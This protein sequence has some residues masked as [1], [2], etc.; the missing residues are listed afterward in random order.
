MSARCALPLFFPL[1]LLFYDPLFA[2]IDKCGTVQ[3]N[4]RLKLLNDATESEFTFEQWLSTRIKAR[5]AARTN[6]NLQPYKIPVVVHI[7]HRGE[8]VGTGVNISNAQVLS[9]IKVLNADFRRL[10][11]DSINTPQVFRSVA[12]KMNIEFILAQQSPDGDASNGIVRVQ[13]SRNQ[14]S[15]DD[16][17]SLKALSYWPAEDYLNIWVTDLSSTLLGYAQFPESSLAGLEGASTNRL[18]DGVVVDYQVFGSRAD[19]NFNLLSSFPNGRTTVHEVG[20]FFGLRHIWGDVTNC[21]TTTDYVDDTPRQDGSTSGCPSHPQSSCSNAKMFQNYMDYTNDACMNLFTKNQVDRMVTVIESSPRRLSLL[22]SKGV[23]HPGPV[24]NDAGLVAITSPAESNCDL[25]IVPSVQVRN[26]GTNAITSVRVEVSVNDVAVETRAF[27]FSP[28]LATNTSAT[29]TFSNRVLNPGLF[30]IRF[31]VLNTNGVEDGKSSDNIISISTRIPETI[32]SPFSQAFNQLP[33]AWPITNDDNGTT[34][35]LTTAANESTS[36]TALGLNLFSSSAV[37]GTTDVIVSPV[38]SLANANSPYFSFDVAYAQRGSNADALRV[39]VISNCGG[40]LETNKVFDKSGSI[41]S[42]AGSLSSSFVPSGANQWRKEVIDLSAYK[43][44]QRVQLAFVG[45]N[46]RG[47]NIYLDN[48][49]V[50]SNLLEDVALRTVLQPSPVR[51]GAEVNPVIVVE[52]TGQIAI[53]NLTVAYH[54]NNGAVLTSN[55]GSNFSLGVKQRIQIT[56]PQVTLQQGENVLNIEL[57]RPNGWHDLNPA[58]NSLSVKS[59]VNTAQDRIPLREN[60]TTASSWTSVSPLSETTWSTA[61]TNFG[62]SYF[63]PS[64][65]NAAVGEEA[66]FVTPTLDFSTSTTA[67]VFYNWS[68]RLRDAGNSQRGSSL[69]TLKILGS[70]DCGNTYPITLYAASGAQLATAVDNTAWTPQNSNEWILQY[71]NLNEL[72]GEENVRLAFVFRNGNGNNYYI[73]NAEFF[74]SDNPAP[75]LI[76]EPFFVFNNAS[77]EDLFVTFKLEERQQVWYEL[78]DVS[79]RSLVREE[80]QDVLNQTFPVATAYASPGLYILRIRIGHQYFA[81]KVFLD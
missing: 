49:A 43:G 58:D 57:T 78:I 10:N 66:W 69:D 5:Q 50:I 68:Y 4:E 13:G 48:V 77:R 26:N 45:V 44:Q 70:I 3:H 34:W 80:L 9:Q 40:L 65:Q 72:A 53:Q 39:Y 21:T 41:L 12:G 11:A 14:W 15:A 30:D 75:P 2:Q 79:G 24:A 61:G 55:T 1:V 28:A 27:D 76:D 62:T 19:G 52:N 7:V 20:H 67:S 60:F 36:N 37:N 47:N 32:T 16:D 74:L 25:F 63:Y 23:E 31:R 17:T 81:R 42:T 22:T 51:C 64:F 6:D 54:L 71:V 29:I 18:T 46:A 8:A 59:V 35:A 56:L 33:S 73:D 38:F